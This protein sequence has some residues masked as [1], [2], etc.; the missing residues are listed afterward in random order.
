M[1]K[2]YNTGPVQAVHSYLH[3]PFLR[4]LLFV[5]LFSILAFSSTCNFSVPV[6]GHGRTDQLL[7]PIRIIVRMPEPENLKVER[8]VEVDQT[9][10]SLRAGYRS[11]DALQRNIVYS[12]LQS[13][14]WPIFPIQNAKM[15]NAIFSKTKQFRAMV[16]IVD[17]QEV[18]HGLFKEFIIG[19]LKFMMTEIR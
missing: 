17:L 6:S 1:I 15:L 9:G 5:L 19:S 2:C 14:F 13:I 12:T 4:I 18:V 8:S 11:R 16:S 3:F 7:S 10:I